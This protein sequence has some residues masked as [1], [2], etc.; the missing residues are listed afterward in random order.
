MRGRHP[1]VISSARRFFGL[2]EDR[3]QHYTVSATGD[4]FADVTAVAH[5]PVCYHRNIPSRSFMVIFPGSG[6][7]YY[8]CSLRYSYPE[9]FSGS[10]S[11]TGPYSN[12][13]AVDT[14]LHEFETCIVTHTVAYN[15]RDR[16]LLYQFREY[17]TAV[18]LGHMLG[19]GYCRLHHQY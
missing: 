12:K 3:A 1:P 4:G 11:C 2:S 9:H 7:I 10:A 13:Y 16:N 6:A 15:D 18:A 14:S 17:E 19:G 8:S 5:S